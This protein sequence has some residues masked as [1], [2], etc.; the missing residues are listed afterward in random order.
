MYQEYICEKWWRYDERYV[1]HDGFTI[2]I[3]LSPGQ[4][5]VFIMALQFW[6]YA[7][8]EIFRLNSRN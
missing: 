8:P 7:V 5:Y 6:Y 4:V 3:M 2:G 1:H